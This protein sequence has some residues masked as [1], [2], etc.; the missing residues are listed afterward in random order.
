M[1]YSQRRDAISAPP[2]MLFEGVCH[3]CIASVQFVLKREPQGRF[4]FATLQSDFGAAQLEH[5]HITERSLS[6]V[7]LVEDGQVY[8]K[9]TAALRIA[10]S[11]NA[12]WPLLYGFLIVP[13]PLRD[14]VYD[15]IGNRRY[16]W[17]GKMNQCWVPDQDVSDRFLG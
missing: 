3:L 15:F 4:R 10:R 9:S 8:E 2:V 7:L 12:G 14:W 5:Y 1:I 11:L 13:R 6:S 16:R 17:F